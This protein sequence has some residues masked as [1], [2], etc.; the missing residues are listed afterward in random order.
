M[1][2]YYFFFFQA[3]DGIRDIGVTGVQTCA[4]PIL[5]GPLGRGSLPRW[6]SRALSRWRMSVISAGLTE[7]PSFWTWRTSLGDRKS[8]VEG[9]S[10]DLGGRR[11]FK[12]KTKSMVG[13]YVRFILAN[14]YF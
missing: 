12:K 8:V 6:A 11:I 10:V 5:T 7:R 13:D 1:A 3:E 2:C 4:L 9:K 14:T